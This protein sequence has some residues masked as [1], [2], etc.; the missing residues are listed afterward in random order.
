MPSPQS[1]VAECVS[2]QP[3]SVNEAFTNVTPPANAAPGSIVTEGSR[4]ETVTVTRSVSVSPAP[5]VTVNSKRYVASSGA[6]NDGVADV[7]DDYRDCAGLGV[8]D[9]K[10]IALGMFREFEEIRIE[11]SEPKVRIDQGGESAVAYFTFRILTRA[12]ADGPMAEFYID[13]FGNKLIVL[14]LS[15]RDGRWKITGAEYGPGAEVPPEAD[16]QKSTG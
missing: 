7:A 9:L 10:Q 1:T 8:Q 2:I 3:G 5:S 11:T 15:K 4:F 16:D 13:Q 6:T 12:S 14:K